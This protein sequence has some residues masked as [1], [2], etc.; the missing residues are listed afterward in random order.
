MVG[1][2]KIPWKWKKVSM[3][4]PQMVIRSVGKVKD[5]SRKLC[6]DQALKGLISHI[7]IIEFWFPKYWTNKHIIDNAFV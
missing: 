1:G 7:K 4:A 2:K 6:K 5:D 3:T